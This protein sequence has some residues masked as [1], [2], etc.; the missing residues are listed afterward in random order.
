MVD[1]TV[2]RI[3]HIEGGLTETCFCP[4]SDDDFKI[5]A[6]GL[7]S[8]FRKSEYL[9]SLVSAL[10]IAD[11]DE[12]LHKMMDESIVESPNIDF[13]ELLKNGKFD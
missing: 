10:I 12:Q 9:L 8:L 11:K 6:A 2:L 7:F 4:K 5:V 13:N 3:S 1:N